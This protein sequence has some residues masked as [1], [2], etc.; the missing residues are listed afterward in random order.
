M[1]A[2][3]V[4][5]ASA[6]PAPTTPVPSVAPTAP[7]AVAVTVQPVDNAPD[8]SIVVAGPTGTLVLEKR[9][10]DA[11]HLKQRS[12]ENVYSVLSKANSGLPNQL[13]R[14]LVIRASKT[15]A[16]TIAAMEEDLRVMSRILHKALHQSGDD[17]QQRA[18]GISMLS[19]PDNGRARNIQIEGF[20][21]IFLLNVNF[22]L[23]GPELKSDDTTT[24]EPT[25]STWDQA[26]RE[27]YGR[28]DDPYM[29]A[30]L[31][32]YTSKPKYDAK[33]VEKLK[34]GLLDALKNA[35]NIRHLTPEESVTVVVNSGGSSDDLAT[36]LQIH[37]KLW[38]SSAEQ[39][40]STDATPNP[41]VHE[42]KMESSGQATMTIRAKKSDIDSFAKS[43]M[44]AEEFR[45]KATILIY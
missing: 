5:N 12:A 17:G 26:R 36:A 13:E 42:W 8:S 14:A 37:D 21:A 20:G 6:Q 1:A 10:P 30:T 22:P 28:T 24:K 27:L 35:S 29:A 40:N 15:D 2:G 7:R 34:D 43:K 33:R 38:T 44:T 19:V 45:K 11:N 18:M 4:A 25:N 41:M 32:A 16:K 9:Q 31:A 23:V 3:L 39:G